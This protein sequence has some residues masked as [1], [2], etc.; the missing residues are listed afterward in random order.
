MI[1]AAI[2]ASRASGGA[3]HYGMR[4]HALTWGVGSQLADGVGTVAETVGLPAVVDAMN[5]ET[6]EPWPFP[7]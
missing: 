4:N 1:A 7:S 5:D 2:G 6:E 3:R